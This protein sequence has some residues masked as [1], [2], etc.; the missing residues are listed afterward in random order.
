MIVFILLFVIVNLAIGCHRSGRNLIV[1][2]R[3]AKE[4]FTSFKNDFD[5]N[6]A[7]GLRKMGIDR[8]SGKAISKVW[9]KNNQ[10]QAEI[11]F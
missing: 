6:V 4:I 5:M 9:Y 2:D 11:C 3:S 10:T 8:R 7:F 1:Q